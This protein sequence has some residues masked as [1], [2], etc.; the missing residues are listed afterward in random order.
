MPFAYSV[1]GEKIDLTPSP[2][3]V[4][5]RFAAPAVAKSAIH[6]LRA[7]L[8]KLSES[9]PRGFGRIVLVKQSGAAAA[10]M[11]FVAEAFSKK[12]ARA[13]ERQYP[14]FYAGGSGLRVVVTEEIVVR[15]ATGAPAAKRKKLLDG[16]NL[17]VARQSEFVSRQ[18]VAVPAVLKSGFRTIDAAN[19]LR[20]ADDL[21]EFAAPN[22][23]SEFRK[24]ALDDPLLPQQWHLDNA[25][26]NGATAGEDVRAQAAWAVAPG[27][28]PEVVIAIVDDGVDL[29]HPDLKAN[30]WTNPDPDALDRHGRNFYDDNYDPSPRYFQPPYNLAEV[31]DIHG[32]CCAGVAAA[33]GGNGKGGVGIAYQCRILAV[34]I[35]GPD[36]LAPNDRVADA[37][38]YASL[39]AQVISCSWSSP[40]NPDLE[41][42]IDDVVRDGR[43]GQGTLVFVAAGNENRNQINFPSRHPKALAIGASN[44]Q[45]K[46]SAYSNYGPG[47]QFVAPSS[48]TGRQGITT[49]DVSKKNRGYD[50][51]SAYT[52]DFGG[53]SSATPLAAGIAGLILSVKPNLSWEQVRDTLR[54]TAQKIDPKGGAYAKG[55]SKKYG[56]GRLDAHKA[57][58]HA[59]GLK[60]KTAGHRKT[61]ATTGQGATRKKAS[62]RAKARRRS[63]KKGGK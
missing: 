23:V 4:A 34:K 11:G 35:F 59:Q 28:K 5:L 12:A 39:H 57:L 62:T 20:E 33:V 52:D 18:C 22:F 10:P 13:V 36:G 43:V 3:D 25:G 42:A 9:T 8:P 14:V 44:D 48:D 15:F 46:R 60:G 53:T 16:L 37:I 58:I 54:A 21:V 49:T 61:K 45:G 31:N 50:P 51:H 56:Y 40:P 63:A 32:T 29:R 26:H 7:G 30:L 6:S 2:D 24:Q 47:L 27:G 55:C 38:R 17:A 41:A 19:A 1:G